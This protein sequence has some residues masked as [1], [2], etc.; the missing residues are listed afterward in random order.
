MN[1]R[2]L[3]QVRDQLIGAYMFLHLHCRPEK[4]VR[5]MTLLNQLIA[6]IGK[7]KLPN[8]FYEKS[9]RSICFLYIF[10]RTLEYLFTLVD[11][12]N[13][14]AQVFNCFHPMRGE[15][16]RAAFFFQRENFFCDELR[17][18]GIKS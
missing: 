8:V 17:V 10:L 18:D 6:T 9:I 4:V 15:N 5:D 14:V 7:G 3:S 11:E 12:R 16:D 2:N 13:M 1:F